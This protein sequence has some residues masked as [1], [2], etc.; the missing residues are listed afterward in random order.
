VFFLKNKSEV[1][2]SLK[3]FVNQAT[4]AGHRIEEFVSAGGKELD[5]TEIRD[6]LQSKEITFRKTMP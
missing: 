3:T 5:N 4:A 1:A 6:I 2:A